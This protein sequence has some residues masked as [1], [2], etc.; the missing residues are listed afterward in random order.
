MVPAGEI[1]H[2]KTSPVQHD[3]Q[4]LFRGVP[5]NVEV[6]RYHS[7]AG[8]ESSLPPELVVSCWTQGSRRVIMGVR[9]RKATV[10]GVQFHPESVISQYGRQMFA[11]FLRLE[12]GFWDKQHTPKVENPQLEGDSILTRIYKQRLIDVENAKHT[13]GLSEQDFNKYLQMG[14][15]PPVL[16]FY[17]RLKSQPGTIAVM[18]E[19]KRASPSKGDINLTLNAAEQGLLYS[20]AGAN[21]ISVLTEPK[22]F[23]GN[24]QDLKSVRQAINGLSH[25]PAL[26]RKDFIMDRYQIMEARLAGADAVLLIVAMLEAGRLSDLIQFS[27]SLGMEP[28]V[29][30]NCSDEMTIALEC[31]AR[32][33][34]V[35][36]RNLHTF[37]VN[38]D[39]TTSLSVML[40]DHPNVILC[41]LS[42]ITSRKDVIV[43]EQAGCQAVLVGEALMK[44]D[45]VNTFI[46]QLKGLSE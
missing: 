42:G 25:R 6:T 29:E 46:H 23:K 26:L 12:G 8:D 31:G 21:V 27:H 35:N 18:A 30:V 44:T 41:A 20:Q 3:E 19:F 14:L 43:Y 32:V 39:T 34:G 10:E 15:A 13:P 16:N 17:E 2:G 1:V 33:I 22:W 36:N 37:E 4:G 5:Q 38:M 28:L 7:L 24:L 40:Q 9:H 45:N 11:N